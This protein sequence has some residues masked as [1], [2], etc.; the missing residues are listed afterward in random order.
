MKKI[1][2]LGGT[3]DPIHL[4]HVEMAEAAKTQYELDSVLIMP[5]REPPHKNGLTNASA[6]D[7]MNMVKLAVEGHSGLVA[8]DFEIN[9]EGTT[10]TSDTLTILHEKYP[11]I[12]WSFIIGGDSV[13]YIE[14]WHRP[15]IIFSLCDILYIPRPGDLSDEIKEHIIELKKL[16]PGLVINEIKIELSPVSSTD[17]RK[18]LCKG[19][20]DASSLHLNSNVLKYIVE[21]KLYGSGQE[22][23]R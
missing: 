12:K 2:I 22:E 21:N 1:G 7:R 16:Y 4:R 11:D 20:N 19:C 15:D 8:S 9:R 17:I 3:F 10:Y 23:R 13:M 5:D 6:K 18:R 14:R